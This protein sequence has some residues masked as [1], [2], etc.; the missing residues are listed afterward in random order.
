MRTR[1][2][3][4][5]KT[6]QE[7]G[8]Y[9]F[10]KG[11]ILILGF[12]ALMLIAITTIF[13][14]EFISASEAPYIHNNSIGFIFGSFLGIIILIIGG[15]LLK[16]IDPKVTFGI[17]AITFVIAGLYL[18]FNM[19]TKLNWSDQFFS[20]KIA[21]NMN[22]GNFEDLLPNGESIPKLKGYLAIYPFQLGFITYLRIMECFSTNVR[23]FYLLNV[24]LIVLLNYLLYRIVKLIT[25]NNIV[26]QN[27]T[28]ILS[29]AF[30][31]ELFFVLF[32]YGN[33]PGLCA[34]LG[35]VYFGL[36]MMLGNEKIHLAWLWCI[37]LFILSYQLKSNYQIAAIA[38][39]IVFILHAIKT[40]KYWFIVMPFVIF[41]GFIGSN[42]LIVTAYEAE[43]GYQIR[44]GL[45]MI[46]YLGMGLEPKKKTVRGPGWYNDYT[47]NLYRK[48][49]MN[50][51][52][53]AKDAKKKIK[54]ELTYFQSHPDKAC[55]FFTEKFMTT[56]A[57][58]IF[59]SAQAS[60][61]ARHKY[62]PILANVY[63]AYNLSNPK[64]WELKWYQKSMKSI[65]AWCNFI[66]VA[67]VSLTLIF[68]GYKRLK[69]DSYSL[70]AILFLMGGML[71]HLVWE[72]KSQYVFQYIV[73]L[74]P[75][76]AM[77]LSNV[78]EKIK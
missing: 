16:K 19:S 78:S 58:P 32:I 73:C 66:V 13:N 8:L 43:S 14:R 45:P 9:S 65:A 62:P 41:A 61:V 57:D 47:V 23:F 75:L 39:G 51:E 17:F 33:I 22:H 68:I 21:D 5:Q 63:D 70:F 38:L 44:Q 35:A 28:I 40:H 26:S 42:K 36:K 2:K 37:L 71:F 29:F 55:E 56:W 11:S 54:S 30:L 77:M 10:C 20:Y 59:Q 25:K 4:H 72:T 34:C 3:D 7:N 69:I 6:N 1:I 67:I 24:L 27:Y 53:T 50:S 48:D 76:A 52:K 46:T 31:P 18:T 49:H 74:I 60:P 12:A 15:R 64:I